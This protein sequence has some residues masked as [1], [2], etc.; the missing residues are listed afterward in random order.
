M[1]EFVEE[2]SGGESADELR[3]DGKI[4]ENNNFLKF[5]N[6]SHYSRR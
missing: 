3:I 6:N 1:G 2:E 5:V 4:R